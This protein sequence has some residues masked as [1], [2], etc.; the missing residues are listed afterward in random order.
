MD[1]SHVTNGCVPNP[2]LYDSNPIVHPRFTL[3]RKLSQDALGP[4]FDEVGLFD[5]FIH[6]SDHCEEV[7]TFE[8]EAAWRMVR[9]G[10]IIVSD[11]I[12]WG[13]PPHRSWHKF[14]AL[15]SLGENGNVIGNA[16]WF[17]RP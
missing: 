15:H 9:P 4:L 5:M 6:D 7:Q 11:D 10:G 8:Y 1:T 12:A 17:R 3:I 13:I 2:S 14:L 16:Q